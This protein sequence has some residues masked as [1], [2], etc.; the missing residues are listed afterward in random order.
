VIGDA[1]RG[2]N[3]WDLG[4]LIGKMA[5]IRERPIRG[6]EFFESGLEMVQGTEDFTSSQVCCMK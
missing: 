3:G 4:V 2:A 6:L 5:E 1:T